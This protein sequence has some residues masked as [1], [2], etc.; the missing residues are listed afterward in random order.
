MLGVSPARNQEVLEK[1]VADYSERGYQFAF[2]LCRNAED[3][4]ELVQEAFCRVF[5]KWNQYDSSQPLEAWFISILR[6]VYMDSVK[7]YERR[8]VLSLDATLDEDG[9][10]LSDCLADANEEEVL[11]R[12][13]RQRMAVEVQKALRGLKVEYKAIL[14]LYDVEGLTYERIAQVLQCP[15]GTVRS[16]ISRARSALKE[17]VLRMGKEVNGYGM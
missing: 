10:S 13:S 6:N 2:G 1:F 7:R 17:A 5:R 14:T 15:L 12:I 9:G 8:C 3:A 4:K 11:D 16:R